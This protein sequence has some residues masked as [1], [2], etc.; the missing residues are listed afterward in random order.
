MLEST[1]VETDGCSAE[2]SEVNLNVD[3]IPFC[4]GYRDFEV[5][6][7]SSL[8]QN[9]SFLKLKEADLWRGVFILTHNL[10]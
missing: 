5:C 8:S 3:N 10:W 9:Q 1:V 6:Y 4:I 7:T 2:W